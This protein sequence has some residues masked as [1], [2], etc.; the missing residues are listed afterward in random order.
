MRN[1]SHPITNKQKLSFTFNGKKYF[2]YKGDTLASALIANNVKNVGRSFKY[3]RPRGIFSAGSEEPNALVELGDGPYKEPNTKATNVELFDGLK[4]SSQNFLGSINFDFMAINDLLKNFIGAGFYY[5]TF[6]WP[7]RFWEK[8]Y[9]PIIRRA[10]GLGKLSLKADP[11]QYDKGYLH[12]DFLIIGSGISGLMSALLLAETGSEVLIVEEDFLLGGRLNSERLVINGKQSSIWL[13]QAVKKLKSLNNVRIL[14]RTTVF[15]AFDHGIFAAI[16]KKTDHILEKSSKPRQINWKIY[17]KHCILASGAI[18]RSIAFPQNDRP[19]I[20]LAGSVRTYAN[21]FGAHY[22]KKIAI[23]T[24]ND[25][26]WKTADDLKNMGLEIKA[27]IDTR[28]EI[29]APSSSIS[30]YLGQTIIKTYGRKGIK[31]IK[32]SSGSKLN[33]DCLAVSGGWSSNIHLT[34]HKR[35]K[36]VWDNIYKNFLPVDNTQK[37]KIIP[38]GAARGIF[39]IQNI[40][41]DTNR[42]ILSLLK[43]IGLSMPNPITLTSSKEQ[44]SCSLDLVSS[45]NPSNSFID[46][47]NDVTQKDIELSFREGFKSVEHLKRYST[48]GMATDQGKTS[49]ILGLASMAKLKGTTISEVGTTIF[50]P[51]YVPVAISAFAGRS[52]GK[53]FRP[54]RLTPSHNVASKRNAVFV[55]TGNWLRAQWFPEKGETFWRQSV[56]REVLQTRNSVGI[57]DVTTLGKIDI[58]GKD[59]SEFLNFV[60]TNAFAKLPINRV[61]YGLMLRED[62]VA[63]D[64]GTTARLGEN[65]FIMTTTT[66][67]AALV[68]RNLEFVRQCLL[69]NLDVHLI[70]TTDSWAQYSVAGPNSRRLLQKIVDKPKDITNENFPFM[71]CRELTICGGVMS[72]L[73]RI[74]FSGELAYEIAVPTQYGNAL[75]DVLLSAG[76]EFNVVPYGTEALGVMRIEKGHAAGNEING[77]TTAQNLGLSRMISKKADSIGNILSEREGF[78]R[79]NI[80]TMSGFKPVQH[81]QKLEA[82][83]HLISVGKTPTMENDEGWLSSVA[84]SPTLGH[85]IGLGFIERGK[86]RIGEKVLA[87]NLLQNKTTEVEIVSPHFVDPEGIKQRG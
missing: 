28:K 1:S 22:G 66:A 14:N 64:D 57:C 84:F 60:Y 70:S 40:I 71:T 39:E 63:Y 18:E 34:C 75:L 13:G 80:A 19:G 42:V 56:D 4:G 48:L 72:R 37:D 68:F 31:A 47:Q 53:D 52:R 65:H 44:Y 54:T 33:V 38:V 15:A 78:N 79:S 6:M 9:E 77:H 11:S 41:S 29:E 69:P 36:P 17:T 21:R 62:G 74:S 35:G 27:V 26:G 76:K 45:S 82:G 2:G 5:K 32:L 43:K 73:F 61:R 10:A 16:E 86:T 51:P 8:L 12:C 55:E 20:M 49:N 23:Y 25:D 24:N 87:V 85:Y 58:Q 30:S 46:L 81:S 50:R 67:N 3:H 59:C 7:R 83:S